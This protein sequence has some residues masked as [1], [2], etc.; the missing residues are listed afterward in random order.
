MGNAVMVRSVRV[1]MPDLKAHTVSWIAGYIYVGNGILG[2]ANGVYF[3]TQ[4]GVYI[5]PGLIPVLG[6]DGAVG[7]S[8]VKSLDQL[9]RRKVYRKVSVK[10]MPLQSSTTNNMT[11]TV[12]PVRGPPGAVE[13]GAGSTSTAAAIPQINVLS[14]TGN[15]TRDS[16]EGMMLDLTG[17]IAGG[18]GA[19]QNEFL[20]AGLG[21]SNSPINFGQD[22]LG[23]CPCSFMIGGTSSVIALQGTNT[24]AIV[25]ETVCDMLDFVGAQPVI[26]PLG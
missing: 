19:L 10:I 12:A 23:I 2:A 17:Y 24:H 25:I 4:T 3:L 13:L 7:A 5:V 16:F 9:Y 1:G 11:Y 22:L 6:A 15:Q 26:Q 21:G 18:A 20:I 8:Y 14:M